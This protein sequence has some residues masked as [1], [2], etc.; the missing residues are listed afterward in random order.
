M[1]TASEVQTDIINLIKADGILTSL[2]GNIY[3]NGY[4]PRNSK[5]EDVVVTFTTGVPT[6]IEEGVVTVHIYVPDVELNGILVENGSRTAAI[7]T[8]AAGM[9]ERLTCA[10]SNYKFTLQLSI[11]TIPVD[12]IHQHIVVVMLQ[13]QYFS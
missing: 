3:R 2:S 12:D 5:L 10:V 1:K 13:Y 11:S 4:R 7:E 6:Q 9:V 8:L